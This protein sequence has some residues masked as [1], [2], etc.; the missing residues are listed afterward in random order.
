M[1]YDPNGSSPRTDRGTPHN[2]YQQNGTYGAGEPGNGG[3]QYDPS[4]AY[5]QPTTINQHAA[6]AQT[7]GVIALILSFFVCP[8]VGL[9]LGVMAMNRAKKSTAELGFECAEAKTGRI[10]GLIGVII[11]SL[12]L[13]ITLVLLAIYAYALFFVFLAALTA[14]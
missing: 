14:F 7:L 9:I 3:W 10:C 11:S 13:L 4:G 5:M 8:L 1:N 6:S 2:A 12:A